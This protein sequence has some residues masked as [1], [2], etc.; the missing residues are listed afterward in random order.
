MPSL[1]TYGI[2]IDLPLINHPFQVLEASLGRP[3]F[4]SEET[5]AVS[6]V[7]C[8]MKMGETAQLKDPHLFFWGESNIQKTGWFTTG[9]SLYFLPQ[10]WKNGRPLWRPD[11]DVDGAPNPAT[12]HPVPYRPGGSPVKS[13]GHH[14]ATVRLCIESSTR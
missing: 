6:M 1:T 7:V 2:P 5:W 9:W 11:S 13:H 3:T 10:D 4:R 14:G 12:P 8:K